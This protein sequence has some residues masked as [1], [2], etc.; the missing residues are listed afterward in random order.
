MPA[1][2]HVLLRFIAYM[3]LS[4]V[5]FSA[6]TITLAG[7]RHK[8]ILKTVPWIGRTERIRLAMR[9][10]QRMPKENKS[11]RLPMK[12]HDL[13][14]L[15]KNVRQSSLS[16]QD[17][18]MLW[19]AVTLGFFG[20]LRG[21]EY[22]TRKTNSYSF[23][24]NCQRKHVIISTDGINLTIPSSKNRSNVSNYTNVDTKNQKQVMSGQGH[25]Q[26]PVAN[27]K[28]REDTA[29]IHQGERQICNVILDKPYIETSPAV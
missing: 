21:G 13:K 4:G 27:H 28:A 12:A 8:H 25:E 26:I 5:S 18:A 9:A 23:R 11:A 2:E 17:K 10:L 15:R 22:L 20:T 19:A 7:I 29:V 16:E 1:S 6:T 14:K 3:S 24:R